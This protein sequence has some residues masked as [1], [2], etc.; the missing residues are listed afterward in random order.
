MLLID[1]PKGITSFDV[2]R[3]LRKKY[4]KLGNPIPKFGHAGTLDPLASGLLLVAV[5]DE[6]KTIS[7]Y[8]GLPKTYEVEM[9]IGEK[10]T[11]GDMEGEVVEMRD[12][13]DERDVREERVK[14]IAE[15]MIGKLSLPV[16]LYSAIKKDGEP[17]YKKARRGERVD[18]PLKEMEVYNF[19]IFETIH[20][21]ERCAVFAMMKVSSGSYVRSI[22]EEFGKRL[23]YP[24]TTKELRRTKIGNFDIKNAQDLSSMI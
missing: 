18:V 11:T 8:V 3:I 13:R 17:L 7:Q 2:I 12:V 23:G 9:L 19:E 5:G 22:V 1:K 16:P 14:E 21:D 6:T 15:G 20:D 24:T 4:A 10:R